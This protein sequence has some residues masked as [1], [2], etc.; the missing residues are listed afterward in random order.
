MEHSNYLWRQEGGVHQDQGRFH[1]SHIRLLG[2]GTPLQLHRR[3]DDVHWV[4]CLSSMTCIHVGQLFSQCCKMTATLGRHGIA[5]A[6]YSRRSRVRIRWAVVC[7][8][9][10][11]PFPWL[12]IGYCALDG[13][14][15]MQT[16]PSCRLMA[17]ELHLDT[18]YAIRACFTYVAI[19]RKHAHTPHIYVQ[20]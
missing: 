13:S 20:F 17:S 1:A 16:S 12:P 5:V 6:L 3:F 11:S 7:Y 9:P 2:I 4:T 14:H 15:A 19:S 18:S 8:D 10:Q